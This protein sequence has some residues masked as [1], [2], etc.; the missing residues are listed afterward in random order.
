M[1][2][3]YNILSVEAKQML[4][5]LIGKQLN[6]VWLEVEPPLEHSVSQMAILEVDGRSIGIWS[7]EQPNQADEYPDLAK[8]EIYLH[9]EDVAQHLYS[10]LNQQEVSQTIKAI[11]IV[12]DVVQIT[13]PGEKTFSLFNARAIVFHIESLC[14]VF[15]KP[16]YWSECLEV[17]LQPKASLC[18]SNKEWDNVADDD[19]TVYAVETNIERIVEN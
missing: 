13:P 1:K 9:D 6:A 16:C 8:L 17:S 14:L 12:T 15:E 3:T 18:L 7:E 19:Q 4:K 11:E 2:D 10:T 5:A